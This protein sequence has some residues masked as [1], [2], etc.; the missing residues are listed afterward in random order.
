MPH[1]EDC[2]L[3]LLAKAYQ[4]AHSAFKMKLAPFGITPVQH[5]ILAVLAEEDFLSPAEISERVVMDGA[6]LSGVLDR[7]AEAGLIKKEG[8]PEDRRSIRVFLSPKAKRMR[9]ELAAQRKSINDELTAKF[10]LEEK[11]LLKRMLK[12][13]KG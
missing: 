9:E 12:D 4:K 6:T 8:N 10:S 1:Y 13:L 2:I 3:Y 5:L 11:L 7:M